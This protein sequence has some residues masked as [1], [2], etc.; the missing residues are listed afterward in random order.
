MLVVVVAMSGMAVLTVRVV[1]VVAMLDRL[2]A[3]VGA[4]GVFMHLSGHMGL[5]LVLVVMAVVL[6]VRVAIM[7]V[8]DM[9]LV[10]DRDMSAVVRVLVAVSVMDLMCLRR[11]HSS[12]PVVRKHSD[13]RLT[14]LDLLL[15]PPTG[16]THRLSPALHMRIILI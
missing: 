13:Y 1:E 11:R 3:A 14:L 15:Q 8:V 6:V 4:M 10:L 16:P 7:Q 2:M 5:D 12:P 9:A